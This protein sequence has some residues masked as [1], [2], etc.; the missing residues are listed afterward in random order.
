[1]LI[2]FIQKVQKIRDKWHRKLQKQILRA[3]GANIPDSVLIHGE[4]YVIGNPKNLIIGEKCSINEGVLLN[5]RDRLTI[6]SGCHIS[7]FTQIHTGALIMDRL[8]RK[9]YQAP[10]EIGNDVW[11]AAH[12][13]INPGVSIADGCVIGGNS[14]LRCNIETKNAFYAGT[15]AKLIRIIEYIKEN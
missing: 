1:M 10:V 3:Q 15:P 12:C 6:G 13:I 4:I 14:I 8:P 5:C 7:A 11:I 2:K 9:H